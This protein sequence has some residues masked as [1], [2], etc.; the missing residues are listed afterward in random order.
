MWLFHTKN[1][2]LSQLFWRWEALWKEIVSFR[3]HSQVLEYQMDKCH[4]ILMCVQGG[5]GR[6][7]Q[8]PLV[9]MVRGKARA[10]GFA[11]FC[12]SQDHL[13]LQHR[14]QSLWLKTHLRKLLIFAPLQPYLGLYLEKRGLENSLHLLKVLKYLF[15]SYSILSKVFPAMDCWNDL[16]MKFFGNIKRLQSSPGVKVQTSKL[17]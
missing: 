7:K 6:W 10:E 15:N 13:K 12:H 9:S 8:T 2:R 14:K 17:W 3:F 4:L 1:K 5:L 11:Q 16:I